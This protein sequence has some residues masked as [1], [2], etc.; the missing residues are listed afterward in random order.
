MNKTAFFGYQV[1]QLFLFWHLGRFTLTFPPNLPTHS[2]KN[3]AVIY[4]QLILIPLSYKLSTM[5][6]ANYLKK[7]VEKGQQRMSSFFGS[8]QAVNLDVFD[9]SSSSASNIPDQMQLK[10]CEV[11]CLSVNQHSNEKKTANI[12]TWPISSTQRSLNVTT[13]VKTSGNHTAKNPFWRENGMK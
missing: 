10:S 6:R 2:S 9:G 7:K 13:L 12:E 5:P 4:A 8:K 3:K 1:S 11:E